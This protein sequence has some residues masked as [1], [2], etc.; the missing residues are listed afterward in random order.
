ME[1]RMRLYEF[2]VIGNLMD[3]VMLYIKQHVCT[4]FKRGIESVE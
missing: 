1:R 3:V 2:Y 4:I